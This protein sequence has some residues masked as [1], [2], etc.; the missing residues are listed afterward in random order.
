M[1]AIYQVTAHNAIYTLRIELEHITPLV[2]RRIAIPGSATFWDLHVAIQDAMGWN[3]SHL[4]QFEI[5]RSRGEPPTLI[6]IPSRDD[7]ADFRP[8]PGWELRI[9][10]HISRQSPEIHYAYDFGDD[11]EH[12]IVFEE[13]AA[14][15]AGSRYPKCLAGE[16]S[17]P[18][19]DSGGPHSYADFLE[20]IADKTHPE[21]ASTHRW[22]RSIKRLRRRFDPE[23][24]D[25]REVRFSDPQPRLQ[26]LL[27]A[28]AQGKV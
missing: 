2:W 22:A 20:M 6:G 16:R 5:P 7:D 28:I 21:H 15:E 17:S 23:H 18:P 10:D 11:W 9:A 8:L 25:E 4:H 24:F 13:A 27:N 1:R 26:E 14:A 19:D 3:D 12:R